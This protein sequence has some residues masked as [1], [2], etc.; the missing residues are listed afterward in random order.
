[1][2]KILFILLVGMLTLVSCSKDDEPEFPGE[3]VKDLSD[4]TLVQGR[5][6]DG[7]LT[8]RLVSAGEAHIIGC[9]SDVESVEIPNKIKLKKTIYTVTSID[10]GAFTGC[11]KLKNITIPN[12]ITTVGYAAFDECSDLTSVIIGDSV[13]TIREMAFWEC[14]RLYY[15][16]IGKSVTSIGSMAFITCPVKKLDWNARHCE[17]L[18]DI[19]TR[20]L[21]V[22]NIGEGVEYLPHGFAY[23]AKIKELTIPNSV[24]TIS[25]FAF[26]DCAKLKD[27]NMGNGVT[28]IGQNAFHGCTSLV[29]VELPN[30]I[31]TI[32]NDAFAA[33]SNLNRINIPDGITE[34]AAGVFEFCDKLESV[35]IPNAVTKIGTYAFWNCK[36]LT[37]IKL[38]SGVTEIGKWSFSACSSLTKIEIPSQVTTIDLF[39]FYQCK[40][41]ASV[42]CL[43]VEPPIIKQNPNAYDLTFSEISPDAVLYVPTSSIDKYK[44]SHWHDFFSNIVGF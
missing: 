37:D 17:S 39:A 29:T 14:E 28:Y 41:L 7:V 8:Y 22:I 30:S 44:A 38:G 2:K 40:N 21:E 31:K 20:I 3:V 4:S 42:T 13:K 6:S 43:G 25:S 33:C 12:T 23:E 11:K 18:G 10:E 1:M 24:T 19:N 35:N 15:V 36:S 34:I 27:L 26:Y 9:G 32:E 5:V 16:S